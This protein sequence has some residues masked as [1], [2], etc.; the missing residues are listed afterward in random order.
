MKDLDQSD[1]DRDAEAMGDLEDLRAWVKGQYPNVEVQRETTSDDDGEA[2]GWDYYLYIPH[3]EFRWPEPSSLFDVRCLQHPEGRWSTKGP[4]RS[5][6]WLGW[7]TTTQLHQEF[8]WREC[9]C[10]I[11][12]MYVRVPLDAGWLKLEGD[13]DGPAG[14]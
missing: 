1:V 8:S 9:P 4:S 12:D 10:D 11:R 3:N 13:E 14:D 5:L 2:D 7:K 6:H